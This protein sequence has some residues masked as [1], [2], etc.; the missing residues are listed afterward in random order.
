MNATR[1]H[2]RVNALVCF[3]GL[4]AWGQDDRSQ[5]GK[6]VAIPRHL[7]DGEEYQLTIPQLSALGEKLF[8]AKWTI[9]KGQGRPNTKGTAASAALSDPR[10]HLFSRAI[11]TVSQGRIP[12]PAPAATTSP[13]LEVAATML[14]MSLCSDSGSIF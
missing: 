4:G 1:V 10:T 6:E 5:I 8:T 11:S 12:I 9:Q 3:T 14:R 7:Q 2:W 13:L